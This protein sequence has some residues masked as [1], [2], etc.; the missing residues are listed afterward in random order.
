M[1]PTILDALPPTVTHDV[2]GPDAVRRLDP[3]VGEADVWVYRYRHADTGWTLS[4]ATLAPPGSG[5]LSLGGFRIAPEE[6]T[7]RPGYDDDREAI[8][9]AVGMEEKVYW[10]RVLRVGGP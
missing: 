1:S 6:R 5:K 10:S 7:S 3:A 2:L 8:E 4:V 9:L